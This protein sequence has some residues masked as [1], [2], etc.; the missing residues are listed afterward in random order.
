MVR[1]RMLWDLRILLDRAEQGGMQGRQGMGGRRQGGKHNSVG[2][3][4]R[5]E[6]FNWRLLIIF[7]LTEAIVGP[8][9]E[10]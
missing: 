2:Y 7:V 9:L 8:A 5:F 1:T 4:S 10:C 3:T 6:L